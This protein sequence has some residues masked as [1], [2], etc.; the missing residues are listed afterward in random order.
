MVLNW[1]CFLGTRRESTKR[2]TSMELERFCI[3]LMVREV[4]NDFFIFYSTVQ[5]RIFQ[6]FTCIFIIFGYITKSQSYQLL[7]SITSRCS[8]KEPA[9][10]PRT[11][12]SGRKVDQTRESGGNRAYQ[13]PAGLIVQLVEHCTGIAEVIGSN[14]VR[15][16]S[17]I[18]F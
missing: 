18:L 15:A 8:G 9:F 2:T 11:L 5:I 13:L 10:L 3:V 16:W 4:I 6:I 7:G 1:A 14:P 17:V 12:F